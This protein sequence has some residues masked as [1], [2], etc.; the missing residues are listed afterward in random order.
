MP[1]RAGH[2]EAVLRELRGPDGG[3]HVG[4]RVVA[5][6]LALL[7]ATPL[8]VLVGRGLHAVLTTLL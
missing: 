7:L 8:T 3:P 4:T 5:L 6:V 2:A 1:A